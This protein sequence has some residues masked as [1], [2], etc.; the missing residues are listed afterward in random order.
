MYL[1]GNHFHS[2]EENNINKTNKNIIP[3]SSKNNGTVQIIDDLPFEYA[4]FFLTSTIKVK[5]LL[6]LEKGNKNLEMMRKSLK[7]PSASIMHGL[8]ELKNDGL[9]VK[10]G[11]NYSLTSIGYLTSL[12]LVKLIE[13]LYSNKINSI[14]WKNHD[15]TSIPKESFENSYYLE[16]THLVNSSQDD[17]LKPMQKYLDIFSGSKELR[18][19]LPFFSSDYLDPL[20]NNLGKNLLKLE[21]ITTA[22]IENNLLKRYFD[23]LEYFDVLIVHKENLNLFLTCSEKWFSL[24]LNDL[25]GNYDDSV[26]LLSS[27]KNSIMWGTDIL[28]FY[29]EN[30]IRKK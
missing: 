22:N 13:S 20:F 3:E 10:H 30:E 15:I 18:M 19:I 14:F 7:K 26:L 2:N 27:S 28:N 29:K 12:N 23:K 16:E 1:L 6:S 25:N 8:K 11:K 4:K 21:I 17:L 24:G 9:V 5:L